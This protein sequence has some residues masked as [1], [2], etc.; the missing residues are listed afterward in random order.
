MKRRQR[1]PCQG[2]AEVAAAAARLLADGLAADFASARR[3]AARE[4]GHD[5]LRDGPDDLD[6]HRALIEHLQLF[7]TAAHVARIARLRRAALDAMSL[8]A[9]FAPRLSGAV[10][11][12]TACAHDDIELQLYSDEVEAVTRFLL[13]RRL[14]Y[15]LDEVERRVSG[16]SQPRRVPVFRTRLQDEDFA[17]PVLP[18]NGSCVPISS[19]DGKPVRR[20]TP[21]ALRALL[22]SGLTIPADSAFA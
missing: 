1:A 13:N 12:G 19:L 20:A 2:R 17:L 18:A 3:K 4:L 11:Y 14:P 6:I 7:G 10:L 22:D 16:A 21:A 8:F 5:G 9:P 15:T